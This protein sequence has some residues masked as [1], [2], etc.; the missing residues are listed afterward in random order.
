MIVLPGM[1]FG[2]LTTIKFA[3]SVNGHYMWACRC[4]CGNEKDIRESCLISKNSTKCGECNYETKFPLAYNTWRSMGQRCEN[5]NS[6]DFA[7]YGGRG[8]TVCQRWARFI[9]FLQDMGEPP[10][11]PL[12][13]QRYTLDR[14]NNDEGYY[15]ENCRWALS[16]TQNNN[17]RNNLSFGR[18]LAIYKYDHR[19]YYN[20]K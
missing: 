15:K 8:I 10:T 11:D 7:D 17:R 9:H 4:L 5:P 2:D 20:K 6:P 13:G 12:T 19:K 1:A 3:H 18:R 16:S 14:K